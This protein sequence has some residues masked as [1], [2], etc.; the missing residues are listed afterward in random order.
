VR[1]FSRAKVGK[2]GR[3]SHREGIL[4]LGDGQKLEKITGGKQRLALAAEET[5]LSLIY[6]PEG[7]NACNAPSHFCSEDKGN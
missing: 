7:A 4:S 1:S 2:T 3:E 5:D 6:Q